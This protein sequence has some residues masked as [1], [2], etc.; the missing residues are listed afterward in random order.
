MQEKSETKKPWVAA[1]ERALP[2]AITKLAAMGYT[3]K[4]EEVA[5]MLVA[6]NINKFR[7]FLMN[8]Y[9]FKGTNIF[10]LFNEDYGSFIN[11]VEAE[12][13]PEPH[14]YMLPKIENFADV[15]ENL[16]LHPYGP[17]AV[18]FADFKPLPYKEGF[19]PKRAKTM[20][21]TAPGTGVLDFDLPKVN[22][23]DWDAN[24]SAMTMKDFIA[25]L[26]CYP[27]SDKPEINEIIKRINVSRN[28]G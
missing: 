28:K 6:K 20:K 10:V 26:H 1:K 13:C 7:N 11:T 9:E 15:Y 8:D 2:E 12:P 18:P 21:P 19:I 4:P 17:Y 24:F 14:L 23:D 27:V 25:I 22:V 5:K 16:N 3:Y